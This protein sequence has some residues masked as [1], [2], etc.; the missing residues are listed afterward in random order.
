[1]LQFLGPD[2]ML[3]EKR[4]VV[5]PV[6]KCRHFVYDPLKR[7]PKKPKPLQKLEDTEFVL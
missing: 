2:K 4:G 1:V 3:C 6:D 5:L 7:V